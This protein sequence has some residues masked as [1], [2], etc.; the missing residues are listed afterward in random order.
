MVLDIKGAYLKSVIQETE[1]EKLYLRYPDERIFKL[2]KYIYGLKQAGYEWQ[3]N[4]TGVLIKLGYKQSRQDPLVFSRHVS[5]KWIVMCLHVDDFFVVSSEKYMLTELYDALTAEYG[6]V[7]INKGDLLSYLGMQLKVDNQNA[8]IKLSQPGY[9][10]QLCDKFLGEKR[11]IIHTPMAVNPTISISDDEPYDIT[12]YLR[13]VGGINYLAIHTRP[14]ILYALSMT[15]SACAS[16]T[17]GDW[18]RVMRIIGYIGCTLD[19]GLIFSSGPIKLQCMVDSSF[20]LY[21]DGK[22]HY[23]YSF[24]LGIGDATFFSVSRRMK[25]QPLSSTEAEYV[26]FCEACRDAIYLKRL[27]VGIGFP[28]EGAIEIFEDNMSCIDMLNGKSRHT[29]SKHINPK[30][31]FGRDMVM[32]GVVSVRHIPTH[33]MIADIFTKPLGRGI[34]EL[35]SRDLLGR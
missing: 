9:A 4:I 19:Y 24:T 5:K 20:N 7:S 2:L 1:K 11:P 12:E 35:L 26:A 13:A 34:F 25:V 17:M 8:R 33:S 32:R 31:H 18:K 16:P 30:F 15:A 22:C 28:C 10:R 21:H 14:D 3:Q 23:G 6:S 29:A 27:L